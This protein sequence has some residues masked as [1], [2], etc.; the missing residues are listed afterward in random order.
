MQI[1]DGFMI[2]RNVLK[3]KTEFSIYVNFFKQE[4]GF[5]MLVHCFSSEKIDLKRE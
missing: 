4:N 3:K 2:K 1:N 5:V